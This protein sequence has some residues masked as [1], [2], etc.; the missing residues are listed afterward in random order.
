MGFLSGFL[1]KRRIR[2]LEPYINGDVLDIGC[3]DAS[4][5]STYKDRI[6]S[7][8]GVEFDKSVVEQLSK[9]YRRARFF[10]KDLDED[11]LNLGR[12]FDT[13]V[14]L[15]VIE[16]I[17]N[18]KHLVQELIDHLKP[19]GKIIMTTP[20]V[21]GNDV[22][23]RIGG[24]LNIFSSDRGYDDHK[25]VYSRQRFEILARNF[26]LEVERYRT[27]QFGCNQFVVFRKQT[28][29]RLKR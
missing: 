25:V 15:A 4:V 14:L 8:Y 18:Q 29:R 3:G 10:Q 9:K 20:T 5:Y 11:S 19:G 28:G 27:F 22:V 12:S 7:Y 17:Y 21:W 1:Q 26:S 13:I 16:H 23:L 2:I 24:R 6:N